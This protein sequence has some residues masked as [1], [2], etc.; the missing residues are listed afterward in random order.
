MSTLNRRRRFLGQSLAVLGST[1]AL[2]ACGRAGA[3]YEQ[4]VSQTWRHAQALPTEREALLL[5]LIRYAAMAP[6]SHNTQCWQFRLGAHSLTLLPD[7]SR[8]CPVVDPDD[9]H[10]FVSLG[11]AAENLAQAALAHGLRAEAEFKA[12]DGGA[13]IEVAL[14]PAAAQRSA[15]FEA[16]P[17]RQSTRGLYDGQALSA[18]ELQLL[19]LL[20][21]AGSAPGVQLRL[22]T[23]KPALEQVLE[24]VV[25]GNTVQMRDAGFVDELKAWLRFSDAEALAL[26]DGLFA[27]S[28]GNPAVP[29][30]L[31][32]R[33][34]SLFFTEKA[35]NDK[36]A[37]HVRSSAGIAVFSTESD[38]AA[39]WVQV[40]R[41]FERFA[42]QATALGVRTAHLN[43]PVEVPA[44]RSEFSR[45]LGLSGGR[46]D[47][48]IRFGRGPLMPPSLRRPVASLMVPS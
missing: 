34:F 6:S 8:R 44:L 20:Q 13:R 14:A 22:L 15:L 9:H 28:S 11:C 47:L 18:A 33:L 7:L 26:R 29:R 17:Q 24:F 48:V 42:L 3:G 46:P 19:Q 43:Q 12:S 37:A 25:Q 38:D 2:S 21:Q 41:A 32:S 31:G 1:A 36:Y 23:E 39:H 16:I 40:G 27:R 4:A 5:E 10:L 30:W 35:E 45:W